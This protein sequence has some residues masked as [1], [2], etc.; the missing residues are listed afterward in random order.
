MAPGLVLLIVEN[1]DKYG[2]LC[3]HDVRIRFCENPFVGS[4][5]MSEL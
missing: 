3:C 1:K 5:F 4:E 2:G